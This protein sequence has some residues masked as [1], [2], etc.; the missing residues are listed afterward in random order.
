MANGLDQSVMAA[1][2]NPT[3]GRAFQPVLS[4]LA[5]IGENIGRRRR[6]DRL[7][8]D[9][10]AREDDQSQEQSDLRAM[11][12]KAFS[13][14]KLPDLESKRQALATMRSQASNKEEVAAI[15][16]MLEMDEPSLNRDLDEDIAFASGDISGNMAPSEK[17]GRVVEGVDDQGQPVFGQVGSAGTVRQVE[18]FAPPTSEQRADEAELISKGREKG[19]AS[20]RLDTEPKIRAAISKAQNAAKNAEKISETTK[21][22]N[23]VIGSLNRFDSLLDKG[24]YTGSFGDEKVKDLA[25]FGIIFDQGKLNRTTRARQLAT[26][27][28]FMAKPPGMGGMTEGEWK[29]IQDSIPDPDSATLGQIKAGLD[30]FKIKMESQ[31]TGEPARVDAAAEPISDMELLNKYGI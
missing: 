14:R 11:G 12:A 2:V 21:T 29:I 27:L 10:R 13:V 30:E 16:E 31:S 23:Q 6:E 1:L 3:G 15:D 25:S 17:F 22:A 18:G 28:K 19:K 8:A 24:I 4:Q 26:N 7:I 5:G 9:R 20:V